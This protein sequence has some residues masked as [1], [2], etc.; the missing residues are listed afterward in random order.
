MNKRLLEEI[1]RFRL[2]VTYD[3]NVT[4]SEN[5]SKIILTEKKE[6]TQWCYRT[7]DGEQTPVI[8]FENGTSQPTEF[9]KKMGIYGQ[10]DIQKFMKYYE[11]GTESIVPCDVDIPMDNTK[12]DTIKSNNKNDL[13]KRDVRRNER[14]SDREIKQNLEGA[15][16]R[17]K[18]SGTLFL[19]TSKYPSAYN[20]GPNMDYVF[21]GSSE[22]FDIKKGKTPITPPPPP[23]LPNL[24]PYNINSDYK[25]F[26]DNIVNV[27][28]SKN[29]SAKA[30]FDEIVEDFVAYINAGGAKNLTNVTIQGQADSANPTWKAPAGYTSIDH[31][32]GGIRRPNP[33]K[34]Q[35][36]EELEN[37]N[38]YLAKTRAHNYAE[39]LIDEI[40]NQTGVEIKIEELPPISYLGQGQSKRGKNY[41]SLI[42]KPNAP[43]FTII[44]PA[45]ETKF[46]QKQKEKFDRKKEYQ[47]KYN[48]VEAKIGI[49]G[50]LKSFTQEEG[51]PLF[52]SVELPNAN[53]TSTEKGVYM[54]VDMVDKFGIPE[55]F[56]DFVSNAT[57]NGNSLSVTDE[58]GK[59][60]SFKMVDF[61]NSAEFGNVVSLEN[62]MNDFS[63]YMG[64]SDY[65]G[66]QACE[67][68]Y[69]TNVPLTTHTDN[70]ITYN[71]T[72]YVR[73][74]N[75]WFAFYPKNCSN[76][77]PKIDY[78]KED[79]FEKYQTLDINDTLY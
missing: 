20:V 70:V 75:Y 71:E 64:A 13:S 17:G 33:R 49:G 21:V 69:G 54:R 4:L 3:T 42:L 76:N 39:L 5:Y 51:E 27:N 56:G 43:E 31:N 44:N 22:K 10:D 53:Y 26:D 15:N 25:A 52:L 62:R 46:N 8:V 66:G 79:R 65:R 12:V 37:M 55:D 1:Q 29:P 50:S 18:N 58:N 6:R 47:A 7:Q 36:Q 32:Y 35:T 28:F 30:Q 45:D 19:G 59:V 48:S 72:P 68:A 34:P 16:W 24:D 57:L 61:D 74:K 9:G 63:A 2:M 40:K 78:Y 23:E 60:N 73:L 38:L 41:R 77:P 67:G 11:D 14:A